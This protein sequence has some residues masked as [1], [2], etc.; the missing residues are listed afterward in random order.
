VTSVGV[1]IASIPP[2]TVLLAEAL[3]SVCAQTRSPDA[4][5]VQVDHLREGAAG[6]RNRA[7]RALDT[8]YVAFL[9]D[10]DLLKPEHLERLMVT[11]E[12]TGADVVYPW[13]DLQVHGD[14]RNDLDP[15]GMLGQPFVAAE[16]E[17]RNWIPV[18]LLVRRDVLSAVGGFPT[19]GSDRWPHSECEDWG[20]WQAVARAGG[21]FVHLP[22]RTWVWRH[23]S[24]AG[25]GNTSG[26]PD[27]WES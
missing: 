22:E 9:D 21:R 2:R 5:S 12:E 1:A 13:F 6:C 25:F 4:I 7:W 23:H 24:L 15:L 3:A 10:D 19:P 18:T 20:C 26:R 16:L 11:A 17:H 27:R 8:D 14:L